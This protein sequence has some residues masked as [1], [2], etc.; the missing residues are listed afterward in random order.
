MRDHGTALGLGQ[1]D[2][3]GITPVPS[4]QQHQ[5]CIAP[6]QH[7]TCSPLTPLSALL[8]AYGWVCLRVPHFLAYGSV[9]DSKVSRDAPTRS[10]TDST[11]TSHPPDQRRQG[12]VGVRAV[13]GVWVDLPTCSSGRPWAT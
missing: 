7:T 8:P 11:W 1:A 2:H 10:I 13:G 5:A 4:H 12:G 6:C 3:L 9:S